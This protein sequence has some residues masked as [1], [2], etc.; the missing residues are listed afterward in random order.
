M[1]AIEI[2]GKFVKLLA[3]VEDPTTLEQMF[4]YCLALVKRKHLLADDFPPE[5]ILELEEAIADSDNESDTLDNEE[6]LKM[7]RQWGKE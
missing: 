5:F 4:A 6:A 1:S 3:N 7:F 2:R